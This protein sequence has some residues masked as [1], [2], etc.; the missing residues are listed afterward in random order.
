MK[1]R[2]TS[3]LIGLALAG[4]MALGGCRT[5]EGEIAR[6]DKEESVAV[7]ENVGERTLTRILLNEVDDLYGKNDGVTVVTNSQEGSGVFRLGVR[8]YNDKNLDGE[9][10]EGE[11]SSWKYNDG[12]PIPVTIG[13]PYSIGVNAWTENSSTP[14]TYSV[15][16]PHGNPLSKSYHLQTDG[17]RTPFETELGK[18]G[19]D[20]MDKLYTAGEHGNH[21][22]TAELNGLSDSLTLDITRI[23]NSSV[24]SANHSPGRQQRNGTIDTETMLKDND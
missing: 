17:R 12:N 21:V 15:L 19:R 5:Q 9:I 4:S 22:I 1:N 11:F 2:H 7:L 10:Q 13:G 3:G 8:Q 23:A 20:F 18:L 6:F 24:A 14:I 16:G